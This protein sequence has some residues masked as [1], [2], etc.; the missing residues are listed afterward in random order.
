MMVLVVNAIRC[1]ADGLASCSFER[2]LGDRLLGLGDSL[3]PKAEP[4][5]EA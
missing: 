5:V 4:M 1:D 2:S 3:L